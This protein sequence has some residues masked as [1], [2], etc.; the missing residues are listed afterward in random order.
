VA[1]SS[2]FVSFFVI[3]WTLLLGKH[4][5]PRDAVVIQAQVDQVPDHNLSFFP[6]RI[7]GGALIIHLQS[8][9]AKNWIR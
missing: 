2:C 3:S 9:S 8:T 5:I 4:P 1:G 6:M 7:L